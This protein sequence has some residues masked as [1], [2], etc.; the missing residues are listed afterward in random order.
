MAKTEGARL[1][2]DRPKTNEIKGR[3]KE[4][5]RVSETGSIANTWA[6]SVRKALCFWTNAA[7]PIRETEKAA[8]CRTV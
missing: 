7:S 3:K 2:A 1:V 4:V 6:S 5:A 8:S